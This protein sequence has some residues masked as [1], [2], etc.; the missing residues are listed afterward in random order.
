MR[1]ADIGKEISMFDQIA[2]I[3]LVVASLGG[4]W[5]IRLVITRAIVMAKER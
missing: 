3:I 2:Y 1:M 5:L 4:L